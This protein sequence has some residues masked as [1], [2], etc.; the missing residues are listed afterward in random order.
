MTE[1]EKMM[2][3]INALRFAMLDMHLY[4]DSHPGDCDAAAQMEKYRKEAQDLMKK[5]ED[6]YGPLNE[7]QNATSRWA[8]IS[9][10]WPW[11][12]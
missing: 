11:D 10:P 8:W 7:Y 5:Y 6:A 4:L 3:R 2:R 9:D 1:K 12:T